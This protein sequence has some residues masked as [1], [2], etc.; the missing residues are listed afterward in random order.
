[1]HAAPSPSLPLPRLAWGRGFSVPALLDE[2][3]FA[4]TGVR[5][6]FTCRDGGVSAPPYAS[7][8]L[9]SH[10]GDDARDV[11]ANRARLMAAFG[12]QDARLVVPH[13]VHG[14]AVVSLDDAASCEAAIAQAREAADALIVRDARIAALLCFADCVPAIIVAPDGSFAVVHAGWRGVMSRIVVKAAFDLVGGDASRLSGCNAYIG[15]HIGTCCFEVDE[16]LAARFA[17][18]FG[19]GCVRETRHVDMARALAA[20]LSKAGM[21]ERRICDAGLCTYEDGRFYSYRREGGTCGRQGAFVCRK[22][23]RR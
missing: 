19:D 11:A 16:E 13:Q 14:D 1:M 20:D 15:P 22:K 17:A 9:G 3:L 12:C 18:T 6:A 7:L 5:I 23:D 4:V 10:V 21:D 8:N 2:D